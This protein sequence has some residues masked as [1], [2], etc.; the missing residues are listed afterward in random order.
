MNIV[1]EIENLNLKM[2]FIVKYI[3]TGEK[4]M[5]I[6]ASIEADLEKVS[7]LFASA[8]SHVGHLK[9]KVAEGQAT[10][11][12]HAATITQATEQL[13]SANALTHKVA[14]VSSLVHEKVAEFEAWLKSE[15]EEGVLAVEHVFSHTP[16][17][18]TPD[19]VVVANVVATESKTV[20][21]PTVAPA[22]VQE[23][24]VAIKPL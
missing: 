4:D 6:L 20:T 24:P 11:A 19:P 5:S 2:N 3:T 8:K 15:I 13:A 22:P 10:I 1:K 23:G 17:A 18:N 21:P 7:G 14:S 12:S 16:A 9:A